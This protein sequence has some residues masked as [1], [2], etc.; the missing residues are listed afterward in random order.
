MKVAL[1][2]DTEHPGQPSP[3]GAEE[4]ILE[5]LALAG[6]RASFFLQGRWASSRPRIARRI[7]EAGHVIGNHSHYH[8]PM[9]ALTDDGFRLDVRTAEERIREVSGVDPRPW[10]RCPFGAGMHD[11]VVLSRL[12]ELGYR[13]VGWDV[14][15]QDWKAGRSAEEVEE[16]LLDGVAAAPGD[17]IVVLHSWPAA[18]VEALPRIIKRLAATGAELVGVDELAVETIQRPSHN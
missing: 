10:F 9:D 14:A 17:S 16:A 18:T 11:P 4:A 2:F 5:A 15:P 3:P 12:T 1:T 13:H 7:A 8:A 6:A